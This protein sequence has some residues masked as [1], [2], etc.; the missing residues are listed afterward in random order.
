M[1]VWI[2]V[3]KIFKQTEHNKTKILHCQREKNPLEWEWT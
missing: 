1:S 2:G 3:G